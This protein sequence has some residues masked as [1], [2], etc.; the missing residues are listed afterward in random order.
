MEYW[1]TFGGEGCYKI[2]GN[3][4]ATGDV[5]HQ[6]DNNGGWPFLHGQGSVQ[7]NQQKVTNDQPVLRTMHFQA[8]D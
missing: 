4:C 3:E 7:F 6:Y 1:N 2:N 5:Q 8:A